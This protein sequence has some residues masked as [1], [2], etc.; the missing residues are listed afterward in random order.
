MASAF[1]VNE[2]TADPGNL[3]TIAIVVIMNGTQ[4]ATMRA[5][6]SLVHDMGAAGIRRDVTPLLSDLNEHFHSAR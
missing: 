1:V 6:L 2:E 4:F 5:A 3:D